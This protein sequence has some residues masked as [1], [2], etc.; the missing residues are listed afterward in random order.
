M[1]FLSRLF[2]RGPKEETDAFGHPPATAA[3]DRPPAVS[4]ESPP[5]EA[6]WTSVTVNGKPVAPEQ[7]QAFAAAF[8]GI[9]NLAALGQSQ[10]VDLRGVP[11]LRERVLGAMS[12]H[13]DDPAA[14]QTVL[15]DVLRAAADKQRAFDD[16]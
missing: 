6:T 4:F 2:G 13:A 8:E 9:G 16:P 11:G 5:T 12:Q 3:P 1:G 7:A 15:A 10:V 14:L